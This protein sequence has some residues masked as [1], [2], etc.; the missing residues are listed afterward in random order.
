MRSEYRAMIDL[1][2]QANPLS[3]PRVKSVHL[4]LRES[5]MLWP[6]ADYQIDRG[7]IT[8]RHADNEDE[9]L[10]TP[11]EEIV[12]VQIVADIT[13]VN[14]DKLPHIF[15]AIATGKRS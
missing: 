10:C 11:L 9:F 15:S 6:T 3:N 1:L 13:K 4:R 5:S 14:L 8:A 2:E 7:L 12:G